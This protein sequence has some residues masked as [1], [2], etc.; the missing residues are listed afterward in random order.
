MMA[1]QAKNPLAWPYHAT[2][3]DLSD[4]P[5]H[6]IYVNELDPLRDEGDCLS[7]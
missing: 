5:P 2:Q 6:V 3:E 1:S 7:Q 4:L